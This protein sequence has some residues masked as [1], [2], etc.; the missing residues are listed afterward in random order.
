M[1]DSFATRAERLFAAEFEL[2]EA[3]TG[4]SVGEDSK[5]NTAEDT[6]RQRN[7]RRK[8][9]REAAVAYAALVDSFNLKLKA[10]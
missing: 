3:A 7:I 8:R 6:R 10:L 2:R 1:A 5:W 4:F 9:L